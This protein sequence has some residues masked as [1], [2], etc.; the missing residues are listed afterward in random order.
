MNKKEIS[1]LL[2]ATDLGEENQE[3]G[4]NWQKEHA[5]IAET[6]L[7]N[8]S[9]N[10]IV[11]TLYGLKDLQVRDY[12]MGLLN[13]DNKT[14]KK[15]LEKLIQYSPAKYSKP[16]KTLLALW[17]FENKNLEQAEHLLT[18]VKNYSLANLLTRTF[19]AG[20]PIETFEKM[21]VELHPKIKENIFDKVEVA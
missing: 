6:F 17:Y 11:E 19:A 4:N 14:H 10:L 2:K 12:A 21:R 3:T 8:L 15:A 20:W 13:K 16:A 9:D 1:D 7:N 18:Q 5:L